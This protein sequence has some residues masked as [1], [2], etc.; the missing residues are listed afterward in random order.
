MMKSE[1]KTERQPSQRIA[2]ISTHRHCCHGRHYRGY[3]DYRRR[4]RLE[5]GHGGD[6]KREPTDGPDMRIHFLSFLFILFFFFSPSA[7]SPLFSFLFR[8]EEKAEGR[9]GV[10][11][12]QNKYK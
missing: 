9:R 6:G 12:K 1:N 3:R 11:I 5:T 8:N 4:P 2:P 10:A 7:L